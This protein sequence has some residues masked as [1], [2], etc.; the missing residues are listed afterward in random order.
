[1]NHRTSEQQKKIHNF[2]SKMA[3]A[4]ESVKTELFFF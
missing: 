2:F 3:L 4:I 1:M